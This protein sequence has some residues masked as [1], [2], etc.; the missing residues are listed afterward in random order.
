MKKIRV[1]IVDDSA[2]IRQILTTALNMNDDIEVV[3]TAVDPFEARD[4]I[5][6]LHPDVL[7]LDVEMPKMDGIAFLE[8]LMRLRPMPVVMVSTLTTKSS[9]VTLRALELG[10]IDFIAKPSA[11]LKGDIS[12]FALEVQE[13]IRLASNANVFGLSAPKPIAKPRVVEKANAINSTVKKKIRAADGFAHIIAIGASTGGTEAIKVVLQDLPADS[14]PVLIVQHI[15][16]SFS[17]SFASRLNDCCQ[18]TVVEAKNN[19]PI[20]RGTAYVAPGNRHIL[21]AGSPGAY[22]CRLENSPK[23]NRHRPAVDVMF[24]SLLSKLQPNEMIAVILTGM[25]ADGAAGLKSLHDKGV[26]TIV[27]NEA[28]SVVWGMP[29]SAVKL[30]A[31]DEVLP[32]AKIAEKLLRVPLQ[33]GSMKAR[34]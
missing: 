10:A 7:T 30:D 33:R 31:V 3:G 14:P 9:N 34:S 24:N 15:P 22:R 17:A 26:Y 1:L 19:Q 16:E 2:L 5:K 27:Q 4:K 11:T 32:L 28:S 20:L 13:K 12:G 21:L 29:G 8:N 23:V 25:G 18:M 6:Q